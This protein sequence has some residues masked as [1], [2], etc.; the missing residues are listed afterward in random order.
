MRS[1]SNRR[2]AHQAGLLAWCF[3][4]CLCTVLGGEQNAQPADTAII[5]H[6]NDTLHAAKRWAGRLTANG[7]F[8]LA[9]VGKE[10]IRTIGYSQLGDLLIEA[11]PFTPLSQG[12]LGQWDGVDLLGILPEDQIAS[13]NGVPSFSASSIGYHPLLYAPVAAERIEM[14]AGSDAIGTLPGLGFAGMNVQR[15]MYNTARPFTSMWY[16]Q[17]AGDLVGGHVTFA[18]NVTRHSSIAANIR[19]TGARG[20]YQQTDFEAWNVHL[21]GRMIASSATEWLLSYDVS[22]IDVDPWS[23]LAKDPYGSVDVIETL[24]P[25]TRTTRESMRRHDVSLTHAFAHDSDSLLHIATTAYASTDALRRADTLFDGWYGG[26]MTQVAAR[27]N[28]IHLQGGARVQYTNADT[29]YTQLVSGAPSAHSW[30]KATFGITPGLNI[31]SSLRYDGGQSGG[32]GYGIAAVLQDSMLRVKL[33]ASW[34]DPGPTAT[35]RGLYFAHALLRGLPVDIQA[36][37][38]YRNVN[39]PQKSYGAIVT[40]GTAIGNLRIDALA[41]GIGRGDSVTSA[42]TLYANVSIAYKYATASSTVEIGTVI[43]FIG[44]GLLPQ[45]DVTR[46]SFSTLPL[47]ATTMQHNGVSFFSHIVVGS[48]SLRASFENVLGSRWYS[49]AYMPEI[50]RQF[51]LSVD[52]TFVD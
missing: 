47:V 22:T 5:R 23:G 50:P 48:A 26:V 31:A 14:L 44:D 3:C 40:A 36:I 29:S 25:R 21:Q 8:P 18:Q 20:A 12:A 39:A 24:E 43:G 1:T 6:A 30:A 7:D 51:R 27:I 16:H 33:D 4:L 19:R 37:A 45:F 10:N 35:S 15:A 32:V 13:H 49:V 17:G 52:W 9:A 28:S 41:R 11:T 38:Y 34:I 46:R 2:I 42:L